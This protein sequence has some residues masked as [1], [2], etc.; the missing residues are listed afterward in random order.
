[1]AVSAKLK[2]FLDDQG[3]SYSTH[4]HPTAFTMQEIAAATH[5]SGHQVAKSVVVNADG[6]LALAVLPAPAMV[7]FVA[8]AELMGVSSVT[9]A[10]EE[11]FSEVFED[12]ELGAFCPFGHLFGLAVYL[13]EAMRKTPTMAFNAG[14]HRDLVEMAVEDFCRLESPTVGRF[15]S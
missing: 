4:T 9:L 11:D 10:A 3:V 5:I 1:M 15:S 14:T 12:C 8:L 13:D 2:A 7:D 6:R